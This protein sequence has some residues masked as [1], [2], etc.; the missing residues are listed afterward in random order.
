MTRHLYERL[1][2]EVLAVKRQV[3][4]LIASGSSGGG[5]LHA[6]T[7]QD[8]GADELDITTLGGFP[9]GV[10]DFLREDGTWQT[11]PS[12]GGTRYTVEFYGGAA[13]GL[14]PSDS[15]T[16]YFG[17]QLGANPTTSQP[18]NTM[19]IAP[20]TGT[21][22]AAHIRIIVLGTLGSAHNATFSVVN[23]DAVTSEVI[24]AAVPFTSATN[25]V[26]NTGMT[27]AVTAGD[28]L[29]ISFL[30]PAWTTNPLQTYYIVALVIEE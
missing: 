18:A 8:G 15:L 11:P 21:V 2:A 26:S 16:Y 29:L 5:G 4:L 22:V 17:D 27:L 28:A 13:S 1:R 7:H 23:I 25:K 3:S 19:V 14:N 12:S 24:S 20:A 6:S 30:T 10:T 9:G